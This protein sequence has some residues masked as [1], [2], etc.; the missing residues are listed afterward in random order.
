MGTPLPKPIPNER[1]A[2]KGML[3]ELGHKIK[4]NPWKTL[5]TA[6]LATAF[7]VGTAIAGAIAIGVVAKSGYDSHV[8][9]QSS[10]AE[11]ASHHAHS[12]TRQPEPYSPKISPPPTP[13]MNKSHHKSK[14]EANIR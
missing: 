9:K 11:A 2:P 12:S 7:P 4:K 3:S 13:T 14:S 8:N 6:L 5:G 10:K 1:E